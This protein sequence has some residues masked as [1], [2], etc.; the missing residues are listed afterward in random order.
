MSL[1]FQKLQLFYKVYCNSQ[2]M[3][4]ILNPEQIILICI[5]LTYHNFFHQFSGLKHGT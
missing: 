4:E 1:T 2:Y 3:L 5:V